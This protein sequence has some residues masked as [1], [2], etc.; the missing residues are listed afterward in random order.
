MLA[1][2]VLV[3]PCDA[4]IPG[5]DPNS[6]N[7]RASNGGIDSRR[8]KSRVAMPAYYVCT[9]QASYNI[10][11]NK[12]VVRGLYQS[13][14]RAPII[15]LIDDA[16]NIELA[17]FT[18]EGRGGAFEFEVDGILGP[19][20]NIRV[21]MN[22]YAYQAGVQGAPASCQGTGGGNHPPVCGILLPAGD[23]S[24][25]LGESVYFSGTATDPDGTAGLTFE[26]DFHGGA[27]E[28]PT[29]LVPGP[30]VFDLA[31][32]SFLATF[33]ATDVNGA[34]C[35]DSVTVNVGL[36]PDGLPPMVAQ[37]PAPGEPGSGSTSHVVLPFNDLGMHCGDLSSVPFAVLPPFNT[38]N[39]QV[40]RR[41][42]S[43]NQPPEIE[44][45]TF[46][47]LRYSAASNPNDPVGPGSINSTSQNYPVGA[48]LRD[49]T[50]RKTDFWDVDETTGS[51]I[52][53]LLFPGLDPLSDE[54]LQTIDNPDHGRYM[55]GIANPYYANDPQLFGKYLE[56]KTWFTAQGIPMTSVDDG[57]R[58]NSYPLMRVQ[59]IERST[60]EVLATTDAVVPVSSEVDCRDCHAFGLVG[61]DPTARA[62]GPAFVP[63]ATQ[64]RLDLE[65]S[66]KANII[67]LHDY[68]HGTS[69]AS[70]SDPI[71]CAAC[72]RSNALAVVGG[73]GGD[74]ARDSMSRVTHGLHGRL[75]LDGQGSLLR[76][77]A[78]EPILINPNNISPDQ[79]PL[80]P[81]GLDDPM[82]SNCFLC[83]PGKITQCFRGAMYTAGQTCV[84]CHGGMLA[85][86]GEYPLSSGQA[87][88]PWADEPRC[89]SCHHGMGEMAVYTEAYAAGDPAAEPMPPLTSRF[90]EN[91][92][93]LY[94]DSL[95]SHAGVACE[96]CHGSPHAIWPHRD[97]NANDNVAAIQLQGYV[98]PIRECTVCH[99]PGS[100]PN[101]TLS[102]PHGMHPVNDP[103]WIKGEGQ[104]HG[105]YAKNHN[106][107]DRCAA[108]HG[109]DHRGT[110]LSRVPVNRVLRD[111]EGRIR[112]TLNAGDI[113]SCDLCH[114]LG[115]SFED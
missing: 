88:T 50:V 2:T 12:L 4:L 16:T 108:C 105:E 33:K 86:A 30:V 48:K 6:V 27:D 107:G 82:E 39:A 114:S 80:I 61:A 42:L 66:A 19:P 37:Q 60:G 115:T 106:G 31:D 53:S 49:A 85:V 1:G 77:A 70:N 3:T 69:L 5:D 71:L 55:P 47:D 97:E 112:T 75:Q 45:D 35:T 113:V 76:D 17:S 104:W 15:R 111:A 92:G 109:A 14:R 22:P 32:G 78:G 29:V 58:P 59:A 87:R 24:I 13:P 25:H 72:H 54:G 74:P 103:N 38:L 28:R 52:A 93:T 95:D 21:E 36:P 11:D 56:E 9:R 46:I 83:H 89:G 64:D 7:D 90:A 63:P 23:V 99:E 73:P 44:D 40:V 20:C 62:S 101:G 57:G 91:V 110:R 67:L 94:R 41:G 43:S 26:W 18:P 84:S 102:G 81:V 100:F 79:V 8:T 68:K 96:A 10:E 51:T 34:T 98:G 65:T